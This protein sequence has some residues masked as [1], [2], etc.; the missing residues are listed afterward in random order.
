MPPKSA[1]RSTMPM[2]CEARSRA[3]PFQ[4][5]ATRDLA[6]FFRTPLR[7]GGGGGALAEFRV[8]FQK[9]VV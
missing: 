6:A 1:E 2:S 3:H 9:K 8:S 7:A 5:L 4:G